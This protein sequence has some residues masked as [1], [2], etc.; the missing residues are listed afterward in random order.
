[1]DLRI[2]WRTL[3][4][5]PAYTLAVMLGL[6]AGV[7]A[8]LLLLG[9]VRYS[10]EYD[11]QVPDVGNIYVVR[12]KFNVDP[13]EPVYDLAPMFLRAAALKMPE[14]V[15][16][17]CYIPAREEVLPLAVRIDRKIIRVRALTVLPG[18]QQILG[19]HAL[20]GDI[21]VALER[22]DQI[23]LTEAAAVRLFGTADVLGRTMHAEG[24]PIQVG[25]VVRTPPSNTTIPFE[26]LFGVNSTFA[27]EVRH[28]M[29]TGEHG[30]VGKM[31]LR[32]RPGTSIAAL[33]DSL[34]QVVDRTPSVQGFP[35]EVRARLGKR[36][37]LEIS[38]SPLR[39]AYFA[40]QLSDNPITVVGD[41]GNPAIIGGLAAIAL[42]I[43]ALA[44]INYVNLA[45][46]RVLRRQREVAMRKVL[47]ASVPQIVLHF[48][49]EALLMSM[50][51][52]VL[53]L[54]LAWLALPAFSQLV[55][56]QLDDL[57]T[58]QHVALALGLGVVL[59]AATAVYPALIALRVHPTRVLAGR[60]ENES[61]A[62]MRVRRVLTVTQIAAAMGLSAVTIAIAWQTH[63]AM[64]SSPG[65]EPSPLLV[66][67]MPER[68]RDSQ[69]ARGLYTA[70][71]AQRGVAGVAISEDPVGRLD[72]LWTRDLKRPGG[73]A[74]AM[75][76]KSVSANFFEQLRLQPLAGRL[77]QGAMDKEDDKEPVVINALAARE[78]G[79]ATP[80]AAVG[81]TVLFTGFDNVTIRKTIVGIAPEL[82][83]R[84]LRDRPRATAYELWTAGGAL[85]IRVNGAMEEVEEAVRILW[86]RYFPESLMRMH[87]AGDV[88]AQNYAEDARMSKLLAAATGIA[89]AIAAF[90]T[91][92]LAANTVQRRAREIVLRKLH[93]ARRSDIG[94]LVI[95]ETGTLILIAAAISQPIAIVLIERYLGNYVERAPIGYWTLAC[96]LLLTLSV[97]LVAI[98]RHT[99]TAM[100][101][102]AGEALR[103]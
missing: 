81:E 103:G 93:G 51:A 34:Q 90:G 96:A 38:L 73:Q 46:V 19:L 40:K 53:G 32:V 92:A 64:T 12:H 31:L 75:E 77:F 48:L 6:S 66:V 97:A 88:L 54:L 74:A 5:E 21:A 59:G 94:L 41:R 47:G 67:Q 79:F 68:V 28:E 62:S 52:T 56:R 91:Y 43:L 100:R 17:T 84:S 99:W 9:F 39:S 20:Q 101:L 3:I 42:L 15:D 87:R 95:R 22:P 78:L 86:P 1:M 16:A 26:L 44:A 35:P 98:T 14:V 33:T 55:A 30:W 63:Y 58:V 25:A 45:T 18:F 85:T 89:L 72:W 10:L 102:P 11:A 80:E 61:I 82:R 49:L 57:F 36:K 60:S 70:L 4:Q 83:F 7:A 69:A 50:L 37:A 71:S 23:V 76:M 29:L 65:F 2:G 13:A 27:D 24:K 8:C